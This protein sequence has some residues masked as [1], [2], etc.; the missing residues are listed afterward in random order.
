MGF[1]AAAFIFT[2][3]MALISTSRSHG[4]ASIDAPIDPFEEDGYAFESLASRMRKD[5]LETHPI[6]NIGSEQYSS[7]AG[8]RSVGDLDGYDAS[9]SYGNDP[10]TSWS[11]YD[12]DVFGDNR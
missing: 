7:A 1:I 4:D 10:D 6:G 9:N 5:C 2:I 11:S 8:S 12:T 3:L